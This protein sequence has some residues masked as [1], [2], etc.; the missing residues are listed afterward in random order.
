MN[1]MLNNLDEIKAVITAFE[2]HDNN[3]LGVSTFCNV[4]MMSKE[5]WAAVEDQIEVLQERLVQAGLA[6]NDKANGFKL[7]HLQY[8]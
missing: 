7:K 5:R 4:V 3:G 8:T 2:Y 6:T 1:T